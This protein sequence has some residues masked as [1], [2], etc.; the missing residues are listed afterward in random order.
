VNG[1]LPYVALLTLLSVLSLRTLAVLRTS[2]PWT[3]AGWAFTIGYDCAAT[4]EIVAHVHLPLHLA[5][6]FLAALIVAFV[7]AGVRDEPQGDPWWWPTRLAATRAERNAQR[8]PS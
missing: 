4:V 6:W 7:I 2:A 5:Y 3:S 8:K 1:G